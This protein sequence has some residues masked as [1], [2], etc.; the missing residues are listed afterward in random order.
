MSVCI[1]KWLGFGGGSFISSPEISEGMLHASSEIKH[2]NPEKS[3]RINLTDAFD[4]TDFG[5]GIS[6]PIK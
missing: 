3:N 1:I 4:K 6:Q 2:Y 5:N